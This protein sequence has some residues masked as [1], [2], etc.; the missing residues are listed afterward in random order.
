MK[1]APKK[2]LRHGG[3][4]LTLTLLM[5]CAVVILNVIAGMLASRYDW[6]YLDMKTDEVYSISDSCREYVDKYVIAEV[7]RQNAAE[8]IKQ[9][10]NI[11]FCN[12]EDK[13]S[14]DERLAKVYDSV[15]ELEKMFPEHIEIGNLNIW[16]DPGTARGYGVTSTGDIVCEFGSQHET[17]N[18]ADFYIADALDSST[19]V[20]YNGE[21]MIAACLVK[22]TEAQPPM[23]YFTVNHGEELENLSLMRTLIDSGYTIS[24]L[25]LSKNDVPEDCELLVTY[26]PRRDMSF[27]GE[28]KSEADKVDEYLSGGGKYMTFISADTFAAG[29]L[30]NFEALLGRWGVTFDHQTSPDGIEQSYLIRDRYNSLTVDGYT[31]MSQNAMSGMGT[32]VLSGRGY[33]NA[34]AN[35][36]SISFSEQFVPDGNGNYVYTD[37]SVKKTAFPLIVTHG[38]AEAWMGG[39]TVARADEQP[40]TLM[41]MSVAQNADGS[42]GHLVACTS[43]DFASRDCMQSAVLGNSRVIMETVKYMGRE[44]APVELGLKSFSTGKI[45]SLTTN[46]ANIYTVLLAV[47]PALAVTACGV[48]ILV[49]RRYL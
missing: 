35:S 15:H 24:F 38:T 37:G 34:F 8:G 41:S 44:T 11:I 27:S 49:R 40:F 29:A 33:P 47:I 42:T 7:D 25:D 9:K 45:E 39:M 22:I 4:A 46:T 16:E 23:C 2:K 17:V 10:I 21:R 48:V 26:S 5:L 36:T 30:E 13:I 43:T 19:A 12:D 6:M 18:S 28:G 32:E 20:A 14:E 31:V 3:A 1:R